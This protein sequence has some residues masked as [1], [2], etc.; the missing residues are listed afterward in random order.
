[1]GLFSGWS[2]DSRYG[3]ERS[4]EGIEKSE[5][6]ITRTEEQLERY[7]KKQFN[8]IKG[9]LQDLHSKIIKGKL[10]N[11]GIKSGNQVITLDQCIM[12]L[13]QYV[14]GLIKNKV[15]IS[16][17][18]QMFGNIKLYWSAARSGMAGIV[19]A[20]MFSKDNKLKNA[21]KRVNEFMRDIGKLFAELAK[22]L[23]E[24]DE[25][26]GAKIA[27]IKR[28]YALVM[29]E[30]GTRTAVAAPQQ[31][32]TAGAKRQIKTAQKPIKLKPAMAMR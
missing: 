27:M 24:E 23:T 26:S 10:P 20:A 8:L 3:K 13:M 32:S 16:Q 14:E 18:I 31:V 12:V 5:L 21:A 6:S 17:E 9:E 29:Q 15:S 7:E 19:S 28:Q 22:E 1:M 25:L 30:E 11:Y 2:R 4:E